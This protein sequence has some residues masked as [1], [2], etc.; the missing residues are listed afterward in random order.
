MRDHPYPTIIQ[1]RSALPLEDEVPST[2]LVSS[3][4]SV[5]LLNDAQ[6]YGHWLKRSSGVRVSVGFSCG[7][8][9]NVVIN[10]STAI[11]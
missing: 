2:Y 1:P 4:N 3:M 6:I 7:D 11:I 8:V 9:A 5:Q 10:S